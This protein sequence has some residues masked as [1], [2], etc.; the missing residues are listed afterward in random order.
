MRNCGRCLDEEFLVLSL[1]QESRGKSGLALVEVYEI[2]KRI[3]GGK[4]A[5]DIISRVWQQT[6]YKRDLE[7]KGD[8][9]I[10]PIYRHDAPTNPCPAVPAACGFAR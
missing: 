1:I 8:N 7:S 5:G 6:P 9:S 4:E 2:P 10:G 3:E